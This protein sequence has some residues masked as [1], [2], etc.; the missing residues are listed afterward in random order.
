MTETPEVTYDPR[1]YVRVAAD[2]QKKIAAGVLAA[3]DAVSITYTAQEWGIS[4][5]TVQKAL[6]ALEHDGL[7]RRYPGVGYFVLPRTS[8]PAGSSQG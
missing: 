3:G 4:R 6:R 8:P 5:Q 7:L 2:V 1:V